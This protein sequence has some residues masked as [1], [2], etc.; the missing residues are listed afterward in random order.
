VSY[1]DAPP[2]L[3]PADASGIAQVTVNWGDGSRFVIGHG[4]FHVYTR[5]GRYKVIVVV[6]DRAG[7]TTTV[8][9]YLRIAPRHPAKHAHRHG[10]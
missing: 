3:P 1:T 9:T 4:K 8:V 6:K 7:N 10:H 5:P 2:P